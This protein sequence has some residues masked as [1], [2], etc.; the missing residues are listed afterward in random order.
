MT[1]CRLARHAWAAMVLAILPAVSAAGRDLRLVDAARDHDMTA[2]RALLRA[3]A[4]VKASQPD[5]A[6]A[7]AWAA[8]WDDLEMADLLI[9]AG[10]DLDAAN[11][12]G[13]TPLALACVNASAKM[14]DRLLRAGADP[15]RSRSNGPGSTSSLAFSAEKPKRP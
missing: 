5:G 13:V 2:V 4:D 3:H 6:T 7:L 14:I 8:H 1:P 15:N 10:A 12:F 11:E 9:A